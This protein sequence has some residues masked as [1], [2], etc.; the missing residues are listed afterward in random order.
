LGGITEDGT[1]QFSGSLPNQCALADLKLGRLLDTLDEWAIT[2]GLDNEA[3][4]PQRPDPTAI[5]DSPLLMASLRSG[6]FKSVVWAT[7]YRP[8]YPWLH[9]PVLDRKGKVRHDGGITPLPGLYLMGAPFLR[10]RKSTF[11]DGV[12]DDARELADHLVGYLGQA[13]RSARS[14]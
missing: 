3:E 9:L 6:E 4:P 7:G 12:G 10:R 1:A 11:I 2:S 8:E 5:P 14:G 13:V